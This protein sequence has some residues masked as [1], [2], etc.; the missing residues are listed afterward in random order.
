MLVVCHIS[1]RNLLPNESTLRR[2]SPDGVALSNGP[3]AANPI[4]WTQC[5]WRRN[6]RLASMEKRTM[7]VCVALP[8]LRKGQ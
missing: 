6:T 2:L 8:S 1:P 4:A 5:G 7:A 3:R